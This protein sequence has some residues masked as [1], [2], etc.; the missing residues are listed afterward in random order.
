MFVF[1]KRVDASTDDA[2]ACVTAALAFRETPA[3]ENS[4]ARAL[5]EK[6]LGSFLASLR[7]KDKDKSQDG[8]GDGEG[9]EPALIVEP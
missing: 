5:L 9:G 6:C 2:A 4:V 7:E 3:K 8:E 1:E